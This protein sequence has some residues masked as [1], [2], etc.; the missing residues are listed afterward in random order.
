[1][2]RIVR[3][4][5]HKPFVVKLKDVQGLDKLTSDEKVLDLQIHICACGLSNH[6][7]FCYN[8]LCS[9]LACPLV[10]GTELPFLYRNLSM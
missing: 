5:A 6:K 8:S 7:P 9:T 10:A 2:A 4:D 3:H 1:M